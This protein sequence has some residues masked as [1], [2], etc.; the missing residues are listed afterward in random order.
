MDLDFVGIR[1][2]CMDL[3]LY[4]LVKVKPMKRARANRHHGM[5]ENWVIEG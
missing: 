5:M 3:N 2:F 1:R 4:L